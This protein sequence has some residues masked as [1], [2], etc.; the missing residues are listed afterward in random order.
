MANYELLQDYV[1]RSKAKRQANF[2]AS[3][4]DTKI[5]KIMANTGS[6]NVKDK[7][8]T[9]PMVEIPN[10]QDSWQDYV[11]ATTSRGLKPKYEQFLQQYNNLKDVRTSALLNNLTSAQASGMS[12]K[13]IRKAIKKDPEIQRLLTEGIVANPDA[14]VKSTLGAYL[15]KEKRGFMDALKTPLI[16]GG[17]AAGTFLGPKAYAMGR[18]KFMSAL[19]AERGPRVLRDVKDLSADAKKIGSAERNKLMRSDLASQKAKDKADWEAKDKKIRG[20]LKDSYKYK[21][22][23]EFKQANKSKYQTYSKTTLEKAETLFGKDKMDKLGLYK[24]RPS[25]AKAA[26]KILGKGLGKGLLGA[27]KFAALTAI[28]NALTSEE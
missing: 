23:E 27:G 24:T 10:A 17:A 16:A 4:W 13:D 14:E 3:Y 8:I 7:T 1:N 25:K 12:M 9:A 21:N 20:K 2:D 18:E 5:R 22:F 19:E 26:T 15:P 28:L 6:F 11:R